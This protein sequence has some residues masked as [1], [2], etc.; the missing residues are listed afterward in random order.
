MRAVIQRISK[1]EVLVSQKEIA[2]IN[3]GLMVFLGIKKGDSLKEISYLTRKIVGL[4]IFDD[5]NQKMNLSLKD[6][7]GELLIV[8]QFTLYGDC[9]KGLRPSYDQAE[10]ANLAKK[11]YEEF[12]KEIS[13]YDLPV[14]TGI[15][16]E[17]MTVSIAIEGPVTIIIETP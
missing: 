10:D 16:Q 11:L 15:F 5:H 14:K 9:K 8:S 3:Q 1:G 2:A 7:R 13:T 6:V 17:H 4:R 12:I